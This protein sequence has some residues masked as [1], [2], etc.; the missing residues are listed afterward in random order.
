MLR[1]IYVQFEC[2]RDHVNNNHYIKHVMHDMQIE[3]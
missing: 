3:L 2:G 1:Y